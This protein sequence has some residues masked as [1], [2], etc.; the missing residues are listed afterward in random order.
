VFQDRERLLERSRLGF[1][2][3]ALQPR[4]RQEQAGLAAGVAVLLAGRLG[5]S[6]DGLEVRAVAAAI[7][8]ALFVAI[9]EWQA[10][11]GQGNLGVLIDR[12]LGAVLD[13]PLPATT[14]LKRR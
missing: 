5:V 12:A 14:T 2:I 10:H 7:D 3:P 11:D 13:G 1:R 8:A 6:P 4:M 9:E